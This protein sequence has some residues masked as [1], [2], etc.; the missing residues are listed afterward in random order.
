VPVSD[1]G[2]WASADG[3]TWTPVDLGPDGVVAGACD[4]DDGLL[5]LG[6]LV[7]S[8]DRADAAFWRR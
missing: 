8:D 6:S 7:V 1:S 3:V 4:D 5:L 2:A